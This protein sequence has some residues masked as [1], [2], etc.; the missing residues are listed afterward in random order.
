M[1]KRK[2]EEVSAMSGWWQNTRT[3]YAIGRNYVAHAHELGNAVPTKPFWFLKPASS[4]IPS[5]VQ[6][7]CFPG[8]SETHHELELG[9]I[10]GT[11]ASRISAES[12]LEHVAGYCLALDMTDREGQNAAKKEGKPWTAC[13]GWDTSCPVSE[14]VPASKVPDPSK[15]NLWLKVNDDEQPRQAGPTS[16]MI[17]TVPQLISALSQVHTLQIGDL[18]L[19]GTPEGVGAVRPGDVIEAGIKELD[20]RIRTEIAEAL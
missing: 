13:K 11:P 19:T 10:I 17:F 4:I 1:A 9:V 6:H 2:I 14:M 5:G 18:I 16:N 12:A 15:L 3:I 8:R 20:V 7:R